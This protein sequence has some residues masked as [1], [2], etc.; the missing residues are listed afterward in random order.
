MGPGPRTPGIP[1]YPG[2]PV[3][4]GTAVYRYTPVPGYICI[5]R[6]LLSSLALASLVSLRLTLKLK[7]RPFSEKIA[8]AKIK[9]P[10]AKKKLP[11]AKITLPAC[12][13]Q[14]WRLFARPKAWR[15][16]GLA[17]Q[18]LMHPNWNFRGTGLPRGPI[19]G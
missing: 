12:S 18:E 3:H 16:M 5:R 9:L 13:K 7:L 19:S 11:A 1:G 14:K 6:P 2:I 4:P 15:I 17:D 8:A 10:A